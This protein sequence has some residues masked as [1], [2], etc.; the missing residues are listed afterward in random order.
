[1]IATREAISAALFTLLQNATYDPPVATF[2]RKYLSSTDLGTAKMPTVC[3][4]VKDEMAKMSGHGIPIKWVIAAH[5]FI[6][7]STSDIDPNNEPETVVNNILDAIEL[8]ILPPLQP[9]VLLGG[10]Q[11]LGGLVYDC[12]INGTIE[13]DPGFIS[14][15]GAAAIP[16]EITTTS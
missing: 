13:R 1:M 10:R 9:G 4:L 14:G 2:S 12:R 6:F 5:I 7:V 15:V 16:I 11:T 3:M 8:A